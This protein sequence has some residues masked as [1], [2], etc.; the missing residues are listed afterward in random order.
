MFGV[1]G[2]KVSAADEN[3]ASKS[4][5]NVKLH[6]NIRVLGSFVRAVAAALTDA[7]V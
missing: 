1:G 3:G 7:G 6:D 4:I 2:R 5:E